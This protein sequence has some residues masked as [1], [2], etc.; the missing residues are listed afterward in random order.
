MT[1]TEF[2][3]LWQNDTMVVDDKTYRVEDTDR[4]GRVKMQHIEYYID[5]WEFQD[6]CYDTYDEAQERVS[7]LIGELKD[8]L[9][10]LKERLSELDD[11]DAEYGDVQDEIEKAEE[12][13][14]DLEFCDIETCDSGE[15]FWMHYKDIDAEEIRGE[16]C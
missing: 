7:V 1:G 15:P 3:D 2:L 14:D 6:E 5:V 8:D 4:L 10:G 9:D 11:D 16:L 13:L 12:Q